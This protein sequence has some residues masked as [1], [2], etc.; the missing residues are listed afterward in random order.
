M[1]AVKVG[2]DEKELVFHLLPESTLVCSVPVAIKLRS[3][4]KY[5]APFTLVEVV[6]WNE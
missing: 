5:I 1:L 2:G 4:C 6:F 3:L